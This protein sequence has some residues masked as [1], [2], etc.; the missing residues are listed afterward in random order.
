VDRAKKV[1]VDLY[2]QTG[3]LR[4]ICEGTG[5]TWVFPEKSTLD[6]K[7]LLA[8]GVTMAQIEAA[9]ITKPGKPYLLIT[10]PKEKP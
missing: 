8:Q 4:A 6:K 3:E 7:K 10:L 2:E 5:L 1:L 9:T